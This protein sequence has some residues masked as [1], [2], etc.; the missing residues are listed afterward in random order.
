[1]TANG[2]P[3]DPAST[4]AILSAEGLE[5]DCQGASVRWAIAVSQ[6]NKLRLELQC[7]PIQA[8]YLNRGHFQ[9]DNVASV[10]LQAFPLTVDMF[11]GF[12][13]Q[14]PVPILFSPDKE[15]SLVGLQANLARTHADILQL[16]QRFLAME[17]LTLE[18]AAALIRGRKRAGRGIPAFS[19]V[20]E[21]P[22][23]PPKRLKPN[24]PSAT[25]VAAIGRH[26]TQYPTSIA[27][28]VR[29]YGYTTNA[30]AVWCHLRF[31]C[32]SIHSGIPFV[33]IP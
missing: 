5:K 9:G 33:G 31:G 32:G 1:V 14:G 30:L 23:K 11:D 20:P 27:Y 3:L 26:R 24:P 16:S 29:K 7:L 17:H 10:M 4:I 6:E 19:Q 28:G 8:R 22:Q 12:S 25:T 21:A 18:Q 15:A 2:A 13:L